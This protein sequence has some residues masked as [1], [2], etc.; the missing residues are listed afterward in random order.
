MDELFELLTLQQTGKAPAPPIVLF[1]ESCWRR[2]VNFDA[3]AE[4]NVIAPGDVALFEFAGTPEKARNSLLRRSLRA[5][6][7]G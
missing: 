4:E 1:G 6:D 3:L 7:Q 5:A 2:I